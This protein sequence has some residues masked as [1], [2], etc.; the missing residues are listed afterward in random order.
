VKVASASEPRKGIVVIQ[1]LKTGLAP[2][3]YSLEGGTT[4]ANQ[5]HNSSPVGSAGGVDI[6]LSVGNPLHGVNRVC[7]GQ[8][9]GWPTP[10]T[11]SALSMNDPNPT[12]DERPMDRQNTYSR[13]KFAIY[14]T[15]DSQ[16]NPGLFCKKKVG[17]SQAKSQIPTHARQRDIFAAWRT[18][19]RTV[20]VLSL[21][22]H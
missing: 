5:R 20:T 16:S 1:K 18:F 14:W 21:P 9:A 15:D 2:D 7:R 3:P 12:S 19:V 11:W 13:R 17:K 22:C 8:L 6:L 10:K 4:G